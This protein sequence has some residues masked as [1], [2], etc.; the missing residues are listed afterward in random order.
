[1]AIAVQLDFNGATLDQYDQVI[2]KMGL[3][4]GSTPPGALFHWVAKTPDG[5]RV[6]IALPTR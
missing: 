1:M 3:Q 5:L 6:E 2:Q 4:S